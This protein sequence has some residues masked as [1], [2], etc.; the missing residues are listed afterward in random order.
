MFASGLNRCS[1][2]GGVLLRSIVPAERVL[3]RSITSSLALT[4]AISSAS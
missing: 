4:L 3:M 2:T 1:A